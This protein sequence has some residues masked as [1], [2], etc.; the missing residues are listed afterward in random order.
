[1]VL[2]E[3]IVLSVKD[4]GI[5]FEPAALPKLFEMFSQVDSAV[6][7]SEGGLGIGLALVKGLIELHHG[8]IEAYSEGPGRGSE[9]RI[10]LPRSAAAAAP[11]RE[12]IAPETRSANAGFRVLV[13]DD[14]RDA[15]DSLAMLLEMNGHD[16]SV[17]HN[18]EQAL[19]LAEQVRP[20]AMILDIGM[21]DMSG[22]EVARRIRAQSWGADIYLT[23]V[24][25]WGQK[26]DKARALAAGFDHHLTK[27]VDP[28][29]VEACLQAF[30][31][32]G[33]GTPS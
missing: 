25:G 30:A 18:G 22:Y 11:A 23:A 15:A 2:P 27:P 7:R 29:Q 10:H 20:K 31:R 28:D 17:A 32:H 19:R 21:P 33:R 3:E 26:E 9:F 12:P 6:A 8:H 16:V 13:V 4:N 5:G 14:N 24:T 1:V